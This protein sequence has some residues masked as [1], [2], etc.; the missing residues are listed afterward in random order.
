M[1]ELRKKTVTGS[2]WTLLERFG[3][4]GIQFISNLVLARLLMPSDFGTIG[5]LIIFTTLSYVLIDSGLSSALIQKKEIN[6][7]DKSTVFFTNLA[8]ALLVYVVL[9]FTAPLIAN[10]FHNPDIKNLLRV[11]EVIV[12]IDAFSAIQ[13]TVLGREMNF[14]ALSLY[15]II[16]IVIAVI[17]SIALAYAGMGVWALVVQYILFSVCRAFLLWTRTKW[18]PVFVFSKLSFKAL[19]G[20]GSKLL[21]SRFIAEIYNQFQSILIGRHFLAQDLGYYTQAKLL[22]QIPVDS[23]ARVVNSVSFPAYAKLQDERKQLKVM[24][25]Q[26]LLVLVFVNT[27][28]MFYLSTV[29][30]PLIVFL[31][32]EK[33]LGSVPYFQFLCLGFGLLLI[34]HDCSLTTLRAVGRTDYVLH[35]EI[36]KKISGVFLILCGMHFFG[37]WGLMYALAI[38][39]FLEL[40]LNGY[41]LKKEIGYGPLD[42]IRD[43]FPSLIISLIASF[44]TYMFLTY[45]PITSPFLNII[46][47]FLIFV[48]IYLLGAYL[49]KLEALNMAKTVVTG[50][51]LKKK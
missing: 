7:E 34:I 48:S 45:V 31:Y 47:T 29:A 35:L 20:Y 4:L 2:F 42:Q 18:R 28:L 3:Y 10:Y 13:S 49:L 30:K 26:N 51:I 1:D 6:E 14:K 25:R 9:F 37:I 40:F 24:V 50:M 8:L 41:C 39:S 21:L 23:L 46:I 44:V 19:F 33:W 16:S 43:L 32:S 5:I 38:N 15:K 12:V 17:V 27:P 22:M 11:I 36:I